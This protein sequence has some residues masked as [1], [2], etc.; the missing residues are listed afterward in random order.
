M[1]L[2]VHNNKNNRNFNPPGERS[3]Q[4]KRQSIVVKL[5][6]LRQAEGEEEEDFA[7]FAILVP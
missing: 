4:G 7:K 2:R 6:R 5:S 3:G 1:L